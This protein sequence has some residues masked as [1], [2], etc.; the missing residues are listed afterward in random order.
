MK[1]KNVQEVFTDNGY[2]NLVTS[3]TVET[4]NLLKIKVGDNKYET[5]EVKIIADF[6]TIDEKYHEIFFNIISA[7]Y[8]QSVSFGD[9][10]FSQ[11][12]P[13]PKKRWWEFWKANLN[14]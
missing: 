12:Q 2:L 6:S 7:K 3:Q 10:P 1:T 13:P 8:L 5:L 11:C 14:I 4:K 9:N